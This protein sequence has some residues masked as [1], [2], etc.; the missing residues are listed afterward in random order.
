MAAG[1]TLFGGLSIAIRDHRPSLAIAI[2]LFLVSGS[3]VMGIKLS[4][5]NGSLL[6]RIALK[7]DGVS[8]AGT[9]MSEPKQTKEGVQFE[10]EVGEIGYKGKQRQA[11]ELALVVVKAAGRRYGAGEKLTV[12]GVPKIP[13][14]TGGFDYDAYLTGKGIYSEL[15]V[16]ERAVNKL[17]ESESA[18]G[19]REKLRDVIVTSMPAPLNGLLLAVLFGDTRFVPEAVRINFERAGILHLFAVS[20]LNVTLAV[21]F[22]FMLCRLFRLPASFRLI[23]SLASVFFYLW[24]V[25]PTASVNR[26]VI[27][28]VVALLSWYLARRPDLLTSV[29]LAALILLL[30]D[31]HQLFEISFQLS[32]GA[33]LGIVLLAP[34]ISEVFKPEIRALVLPAA[35]TLGAQLSVEPVLAYNFNQLSVVGILA[36]MILVP[37]VALMTGIGFLATA[38]ALISQ[39]AAG[40]LFKMLIPLV[41]ML[42]YGAAFFGNLPGASMGIGRPSPIGILLYLIVLAAAAFGLNRV[43][44]KA[45]FG[46]FIIVILIIFAFGIWT[47]IPPTSSPGGLRVDFLDVG[48]GD[49]TLITSPEGKVILVD[50]GPD[51]SVLRGSL[52][53]RGIRKID[54]LII[55][56]AHAD[57]VGGLLGVVQRYPIGMVIDPGFPHPSPVYKELLLAIKAKKINYKLARAGDVYRLG[58]ADL[59]IFLPADYFIKGSNSDVNNSSIV[60]LLT[61][62]KFKLLL[63][64][65]MER[66]AIAMLLKERAG[67]AATVIKVPHHGSRTGTTAALLRAVRPKEA[68]ISVGADNRYGHPHRQTLSL[69]RAAGVRYWRTDINGAVHLESDGTSYSI[70]SEK[71]F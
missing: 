71:G 64:G 25:G 53:T 67:I 52:A 65:D 13:R 7:N 55:S 27:M 66:E 38:V 48:Q 51:Y 4:E 54:L 10:Y 2:V 28:V 3:L 15:S 29:S 17:S 1:F 43:K 20:G 63:P 58:K 57:H 62:G 68:V 56:H 12:K 46:I 34:V 19:F 31:P 24:I 11:Q 33:V 50:G 42:N 37:P 30:A 45:D 49:S 70:R 39:S 18:P 5:V 69:L 60:G 26:A 23:A 14:S 6:R 61:Y 44:Q 40:L 59:H 22:V 21:A 36:N 47:Q 32:F 9:V 8:L 35:V 41:A 16:D